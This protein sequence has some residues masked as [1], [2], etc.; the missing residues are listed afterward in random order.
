VG[1]CPGHRVV[2][3]IRRAEAGAWRPRRIAGRRRCTPQQI[4]AL[5]QETG[6]DQ[7]VPV[8]YVRWATGVLGGDF[9]RSFIKRRPV[10]EL[11]E[12]ALPATLELTV[13]AA[14][15]SILVGVPIGIV[16]GL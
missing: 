16:S 4:A 8:Q 12:A 7:P 3:G 6:L 5:R 15:L 9:G 10:T 2:R 1:S 11:I 14:A 13:V